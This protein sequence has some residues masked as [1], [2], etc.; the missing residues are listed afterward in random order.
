MKKIVALLFSLFV[1]FYIPSVI[2]ADAKA[3]S[4]VSNVSNA[5]DVQVLLVLLSKKATIHA[6]N[7]PGIYLLTLKGVNSNVVYFSDRP[8]RI[9]GH[10]STEKLVSQWK[11]GDFRKIAPNAVM[12]AI[13]FDK[14]TDKLKENDVKTYAVVLHKPT[15]NKAHQELTFEVNA[16]EGNKLSLPATGKS[17]YVAIFIDSVCLT[18]IGG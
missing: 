3:S 16:L 4:I 11:T 6:T 1:L 17:D 15:Y 13:G 10:I 5:K 12:E 18:C 8:A 2:Y 14:R 7:T 9:S